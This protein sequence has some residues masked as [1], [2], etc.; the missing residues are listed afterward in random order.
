MGRTK[1]N[2]LATADETSTPPTALSE[3][4]SICRVVRAT[5]NNLYLVVT[6]DGKEI[7]AELPARFRSTIWLKRGGYVL[8]NTKAFGDRQ[9]KIE[10]EIDNVARDEKQ[11][12]KQAYW[13]PEFPKRSSLE[14][15]EE[16]D[17]VVGKLPPNTD[18][19]SDS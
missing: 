5:G 1:R 12:R 2:L 17:S 18:S 15:S 16:E 8:V 6:A 19:E 13:P 11:W 10:G 14:D 3:T 7:L 4:Q 9:N